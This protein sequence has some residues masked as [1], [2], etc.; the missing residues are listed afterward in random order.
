MFALSTVQ[1]SI[2]QLLNKQLSVNP[3]VILNRLPISG[4]SLRDV[5]WALHVET[6][7]ARE[8]KER[9]MSPREPEHLS[10]PAR[11]LIHRVM[12]LQSLVKGITVGHLCSFFQVPLPLLAKLGSD[13]PSLSEDYLAAK[14][15]ARQVN[16]MRLAERYDY[17]LEEMNPR[18]WPDLL[19]DPSDVPKVLPPFPARHP[20]G[21]LN[22]LTSA[23]LNLDLLFYPGAEGT[24]ATAARWGIIRDTLTRHF[25]ELRI[26]RRPWIRIDKFN[27]SNARPAGNGFTFEPQDLALVLLLARVRGWN[28]EQIR[29]MYF[30]RKEQK[31]V[32]KAIDRGKIPI[33]QRK[34]K[35]VSRRLRPEERGYFIDLLRDHHDK[36]T[37]IELANFGTISENAVTDLFRELKFDEAKLNAARRSRLLKDA[38]LSDPKS[39]LTGW[40]YSDLVQLN[41]LH[42]IENVPL[43]EISLLSLVG[44]HSVEELSIALKQEIPSARLKADPKTL[45]HLGF[46][47]WEE[48]I[49]VCHA[50]KYAGQSD[51]I[52]PSRFWRAK[53]DTV[54][55]RLGNHSVTPGS[56]HK[57]SRE[58]W[59]AA[60]LAWR[61]QLFKNLNVNLE[62]CALPIEDIALIQMVSTHPTLGQ[63]ALES[64][65]L[66]GLFSASDIQTAIKIE[67]PFPRLTLQ[68][69]S[70]NDKLTI[71]ETVVLQAACRKYYWKVPTTAFRRFFNITAD[72]LENARQFAE[73]HK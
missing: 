58:Y 1:I 38:A 23:A 6:F 22:E 43:K 40:T 64:G 25:R 32:E 33:L 8:V 51:A 53:S 2:I 21:R 3:P 46:D 37:N 12:R 71:L 24:S 49:M 45:R 34:G 20:T 68:E 36:I 41:I 16:L 35:S 44:E 50:R 13:G 69:K 72:P 73:K 14:K 47:N 28:A 29:S 39:P 66:A 67:L 18:L 54:W 59:R 48:R 60:R 57:I 11:D 30:P 7:Y 61:A 15:I 27:A 42:V 26:D 62:E 55:F 17:S 70:A 4:L 65:K 63:T 19:K 56:R 5:E 52:S 9:R 10:E 31:T